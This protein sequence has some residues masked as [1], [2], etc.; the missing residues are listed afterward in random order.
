MQWYNLVLLG[1]TGI[2]LTVHSGID[3]DIYALI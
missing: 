3:I 1:I 2:Q